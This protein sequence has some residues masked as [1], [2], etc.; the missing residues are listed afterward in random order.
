MDK[1]T[2]KHNRAQGPSTEIIK[3]ATLAENT[4]VHETFI[5]QEPLDGNSPE[6]SAS[7]FELVVVK[8][9]IFGDASDTEHASDNT[10]VTGTDFMVDIGSTGHVSIKVSDF[11]LLSSLFWQRE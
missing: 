10:S 6:T 9:E 1:Q 7:H 2:E 11:L 4:P 3:E 5:K 8:S